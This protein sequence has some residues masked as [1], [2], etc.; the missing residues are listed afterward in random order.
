[1]KFERPLIPATLIK[2]YKR[3]LA[4]VELENGEVITVHCPNSGAMTTCAEPGR[5]VLISDSQ[6]PKRKLRYTF[7]MIRMGPTW[8][9]VNTMNPNRA[10]EGFIRADKIPE[11]MGYDTLRREVK[12][13]EGG[14]SRIDILLTDCPAG[15]PDCY[16]EIKNSTLRD[17]HHA[18]FPD[19]VTERGRKHLNDLAGVVKD[20]GRGVIFF[21][22][23]RAD[24]HRFRPADEIDPAYGETLRRVLR[25]GVE[26]LAWR[27]RCNP[28]GIQLVDRLPV[29]I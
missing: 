24:C 7:E 22:I 1:M 4:D 11:L 9:G 29:D 10:V 28:Q 6:N 3:F 27:M 5:P 19:G 21:F 12:Y 2:R 8:V 17:G 14:R 18:A 15:R 13:G 20:G 26:V 25:E 23:G 16:V